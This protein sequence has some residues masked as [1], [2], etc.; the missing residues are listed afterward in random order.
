[1]KLSETTPTEEQVGNELTAVVFELPFQVTEE[2]VDGMN[3]ANNVVYLTWVQMAATAHWRAAAT[4]EQ[5]A[6]YR[7]VV[8][9]H[10]V[11]YLSPAFAEDNLLART[12]VGEV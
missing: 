8:V 6:D 12:W 9:R 1:M 3:H 7:W 10:E 11:D 2:E 5:Q 4:P